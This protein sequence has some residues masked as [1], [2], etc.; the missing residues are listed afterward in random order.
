MTSNGL[1]TVPSSAHRADIGPNEDRCKSEQR[2]SEESGGAIAAKA[3]SCVMS[4]FEAPMYRI[5]PSSP[6]SNQDLRDVAEGPIVG[7]IVRLE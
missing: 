6:K 4:I 7:R 1:R 2:F 3:F 5:S